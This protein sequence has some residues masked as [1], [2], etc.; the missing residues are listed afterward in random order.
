MSNNTK[1][2]LSIISIIALGLCVILNLLGM[3]VLKKQKDQCDQACG[4]LVFVAI[5]L[6]GVSQLLGETSNFDIASYGASGET[7]SCETAYVDCKR[8]KRAHKKHHKHP[9]KHHK[10]GELCTTG[11]RNACGSRLE[12]VPKNPGTAGGPGECELPKHKKHH[13]KHRSHLTCDDYAPGGKNYGQ[14]SPLGCCTDNSG[15]GLFP[16]SAQ[17]VAERCYKN[18]SYSQCMAGGDDF[19]ETSWCSGQTCKY[20]DCIN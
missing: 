4:M 14:L 18:I 15:D 11:T 12:C 2:T 7:E 6:I 10:I 16:R 13:K 3:S 19:A 5:V 1:K 8:A 17:E 9:S 20:E